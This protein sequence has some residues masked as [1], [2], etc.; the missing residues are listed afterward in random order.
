MEASTNIL[1]S[2]I[3]KT[4]SKTSPQ[5]RIY[6]YLRQEVHV[7]IWADLLVIHW[8]DLSH[9][10]VHLQS[11]T[12]VCT[13]IIIKRQKQPQVIET[14]KTDQPHRSSTETFLLMFDPSGDTSLLRLFILKSFWIET[15][16]RVTVGT[17][18]DQFSLSDFLFVFPVKHEKACEATPETQCFYTPAASLTLR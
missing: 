10:N 9:R 8:H 2:L 17:S 6:I 13:H 1:L 14:M 12:A 7:Y 11:C 3:N 15:C 16:R 5:R 18:V 4:G